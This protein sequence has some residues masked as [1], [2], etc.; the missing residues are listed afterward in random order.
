MCIQHITFVMKM[1]KM[2]GLNL[3]MLLFIA[4]ATVLTVSASSGE[5][6]PTIIMFK[7]KPDIS[8]VSSLGGQVK[9]IYRFKPALAA[10]LPEA[11]VDGL[12]RNPQI[13]YVVR[14]LPIHPVGQVVPWGVERIGATAVHSSGNKG[15]GINVAV[16]DT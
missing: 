16:L 3:I 10:L 14:D 9:V 15:A 6:V 1:K 8:V 4:F 7:E 5:L 12:S 13:A 2:I 11:A